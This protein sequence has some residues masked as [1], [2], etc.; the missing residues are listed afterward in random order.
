MSDGPTVQRRADAVFAAILEGSL[1][2][3]IEGH[4]TMD[5]VQDIH[6]RIEA[7]QQIGKSVMRINTTD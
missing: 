6:A 1:S 3:E 5:E 7:R 4:Y 2:V